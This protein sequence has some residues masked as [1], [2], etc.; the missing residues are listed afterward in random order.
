[1]GVCILEE[2]A[3]DEHHW[4]TIAKDDPKFAIHL[5]KVHIAIQA[6]I[7]EKIQPPQTNLGIFAME[8]QTTKHL[9]RGG[10]VCLSRMATDSKIFFH[11]FRPSNFEHLYANWPENVV[12]DTKILWAWEEHTKAVM[13]RCWGV[14]PGR[15]SHMEDDDHDHNHNHTQHDDNKDDDDDYD[16]ELAR[17]IMEF[18]AEAKLAFFT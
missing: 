17:R 11:S 8:P 6:T 5:R 3:A 10:D 1:M 16:P 7:F 2:A 15:L 12:I 14:I 4:E 18:N 13:L 9:A